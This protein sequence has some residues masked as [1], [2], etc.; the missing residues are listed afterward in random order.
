MGGAALKYISHLGNLNTYRKLKEALAQRFG[1][2]D[3]PTLL[4]RQ[5]GS[6]R[7]LESETLEEYSERVEVMV[8]DAYPSATPEVEN[9]LAVETFFRGCRERK[10]TEIAMLREPANIREARE[11][12][13]WAL[14]SHQ[15]IF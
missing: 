6:L 11:A 4:R 7:Q 15:A 13:K 10:A 5:L 12:V 9:P 2:K 3:P 14:S 8:R 1:A